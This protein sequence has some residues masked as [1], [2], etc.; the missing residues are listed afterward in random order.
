MSCTFSP[1]TYK[2]GKQV[3]ENYCSGCHG[4]KMEGLKDLYPS[5]DDIKWYDQNRNHIPCWLKHGITIKN[6]KRG[7]QEMPAHTELSNI[8]ICNVLNYLNSSNWKLKTPFSLEEIDY[9]LKECS[10]Q[11]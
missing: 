7:K 4:I 11:K 8:Q 9:N 1:E 3:Y 6:L 2:E 5:L 10:N